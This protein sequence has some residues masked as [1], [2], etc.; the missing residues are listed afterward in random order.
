MECKICGAKTTEK[1][2]CYLCTL[3]EHRTCVSF[4][5]ATP[6]PDPSLLADALDYAERLHGKPEAE[7]V[8]KF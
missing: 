3:D 2:L 4:W 1:D 8:E 7:I 6:D 5:E